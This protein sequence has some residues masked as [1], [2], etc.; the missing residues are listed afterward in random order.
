MF[1]FFLFLKALKHRAFFLMTGGVPAVGISV[2]EHYH[3]STL[4]TGVFFTIALLVVGYSLFLVWRDE[5]DKVEQLTRHSNAVV[6]ELSTLR[7]EAIEQLLN[8]RVSNENDVKLLMQEQDAWR[9]RV[10]AAL[11]RHGAGEPVV[12]SFLYLGVLYLVPFKNAISASHEHR[13]QI[14]ARQLD[15]IEIDRKICGSS[16]RN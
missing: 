16:K 7:A 15:V 11:R 2:W 13:L 3:Q 12:N 9:D 6:E 10:V 8:K 1:K 4:A 5:H 14:L